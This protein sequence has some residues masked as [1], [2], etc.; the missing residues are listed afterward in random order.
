MKKSHF[1]S[2]LSII[3]FFSFFN[4]EVSASSNKHEFTVASRGVKFIEVNVPENAKEIKAVISGQTEMVKLALFAPGKNT[5]ASKNSTWSNLS[6]WKKPIE[7]SKSKPKAGS[8]RIKIEGAVHVGKLDKIKS[9][10]GFL[11]VFI[12]GVSVAYLSAS[13]IKSNTSIFPIIKEYQFT[14]PSRG[15]K[16]YEVNIPENAK[17]IKAVISGHTEMLKLALLAPGKTVPSSKNSTWS[18]LSNWKKPFKCS[19]NKPQA[20]TWRIKIEGAV[21][22]GKL[23]QIKSVSGLLTIT[24]DGGK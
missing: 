5:P 16:Y 10:S 23:D 21:H 6:N 12:D 7:C 18:N 24:V 2:L 22:T 1:F 11:E 4:T 15:I 9:V 17:E 20:G 14:I 3:I 13:D 19:K 8:W